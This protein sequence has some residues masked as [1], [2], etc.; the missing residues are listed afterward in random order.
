MSTDR[1]LHE[2]AAK[3][4]DLSLT[5]EEVKVQ[6]DEN[7]ATDPQQLEQLQNGIDKATALIEDAVDPEFPS[8]VGA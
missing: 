6:V 2:I 8:K 1:T 5:L 7:A 3:L 4:D